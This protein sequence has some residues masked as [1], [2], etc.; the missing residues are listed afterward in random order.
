VTT[1]WRGFVE[2]SPDARMTTSMLVEPIRF[3]RRTGGRPHFAPAL[4]DGPP[5]A[6]ERPAKLPRVLWVELTSRCPYDCPFCSRR[7]LRGHGRHMPLELYR[8]IVG[9]LERP[10]VVRLNYS[11]ES[12]HYPHILEAVALAAASGAWVELVSVPAALPPGRLEAIVRCGLNRLTISLHTLDAGEFDALYGFGDLERLCAAV[13]EAA[14]LRGVVAHPFVVDL[15]FVAMARNLGQL[16]SVVAFADALRLQVV[17]IHPVIRRSPIGETFAAELEASGEL[18]D[19]F[20]VQLQQA[21][22]EVRAQHP[23]MRLQF[24]SPEPGACPVAP[25][26][27]PHYATGPLSAGDEIHGCDQDPFETLHVL[28]DGRVVTCEVRDAQTMGDLRTESLRGIWHGE[29]YRRF[30]AQYA[31]GVDP[32]CRR[33]PYKRVL[34][35]SPPGA[36]LTPDCNVAQLLRGWHAAE[37]TLVWSKCE[38]SLVLARPAGARA[39]RIQGLLPGHAGGGNSMTVRVDGAEAATVRNG[40]AALVPIDCRIPLPA[41]G[42]R[43]QVEVDLEIARRHQPPCGRRLDTRELGFALLRA[44]VR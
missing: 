9:E 35:P 31:S 11:G 28:A 20:R 17:S 39:L 6:G 44:E 23:R 37:A 8:R 22:A 3:L 15:A 7:L 18:G 10:E 38:A 36:R 24:S 34:R 41:A 14:A 26:G 13:R 21:V 12:T 2:R 40:G 25:P 32:Q 19:V 27:A 16:R 1:A 33:C 42:G 43:S 4:L 30:R 5:R 29:A